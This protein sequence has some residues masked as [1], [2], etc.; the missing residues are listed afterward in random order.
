MSLDQKTVEHVA[1]LAR[2]ALSPED[3]AARTA[4][5]E[6]ILDVIAEMQAIHTEGVTPM[7]HP[8]DL[9]QPLRPDV[10]GNADERDKLM[11][12]APSQAAGL[13]RVPKVIE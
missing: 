1:H 4:Q 8:L 12:N 9:S 13:F 2:L 3:L 5:L 7:A 6:R 11:Q 10:V